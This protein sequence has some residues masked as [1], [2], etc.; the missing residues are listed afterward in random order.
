MEATLVAQL[1]LFDLVFARNSSLGNRSLTKPAEMNIPEQELPC[2]KL[3]TTK[4][5]TF[6]PKLRLRGAS[7]R[8]S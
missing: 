8:T 5:V 7:E 4:T 2:T 3:P 1:R 6:P